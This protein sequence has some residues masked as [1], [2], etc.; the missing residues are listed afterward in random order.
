MTMMK[1]LIIFNNAPKYLF[2]RLSKLLKKK[3]NSSNITRMLALRKR[4][5]NSALHSEI[6]PKCQ[7]LIF[8]TIIKIITK[9]LTLKSFEIQENYM[10]V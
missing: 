9:V 8:A 3:K 4:S 1:K 7:S 6:F 5:L 10:T 2:I